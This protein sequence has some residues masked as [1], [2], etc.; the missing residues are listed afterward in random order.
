MSSEPKYGAIPR[1]CLDSALG[2][3]TPQRFFDPALT[4]TM[5]KK[6]RM[7]PKIAEF[8]CCISSFVYAGGVL[9]YAL[10]VEDWWKGWISLG[11]IPSYV[12]LAN[13]LGIFTAVASAVYHAYLWEGCGSCDC[14]LAIVLWLACVLSCFGLPFVYQAC[15]LCPVVTVFACLWRRATKLAVVCG[16]IVFPFSIWSCILFGWMWGATVL[17]LLLA[18]IVC[19]LLD[20]LQVLPL[21]TFWHIFSG[22][23]V[24]VSMFACMQHGPGSD[25]FEGKEWF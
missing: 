6:Y 8:W 18:G 14:S 5:E 15:I 19:F 1:S 24:T 23:A 10:R 11:H 12:H 13:I 2:L 17:S 21:H 20:R 3:P 22:A 9:V 7:H 16:A 25:F 4:T